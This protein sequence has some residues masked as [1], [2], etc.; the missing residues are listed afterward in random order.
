MKQQSPWT[1]NVAFGWLASEVDQAEF[2]LGEAEEE[3]N[4]LEKEKD[5][6]YLFLKIYEKA[7]MFVNSALNWADELDSLK[8][9]ENFTEEESNY[10]CWAEE[11]Q[12]ELRQLWRR[13]LEIR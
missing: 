4:R 5:G 12:T 11:N 3:L 7:Q 8:G 1:S 2:Y 13:W 6:S 9:A 10:F